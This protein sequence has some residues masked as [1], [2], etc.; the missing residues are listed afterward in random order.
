MEEELYS[1]TGCAFPAEDLSSIDKYYPRNG[2]FSLGVRA[3]VSLAIWKCQN[4]VQ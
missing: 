3:G 1:P 4:I 2:V